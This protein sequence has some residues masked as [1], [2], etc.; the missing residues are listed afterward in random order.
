M[1]VLD[2]EKIK[3]DFPILKRKMHGKRLV[4]LDSA[5]TSQKPKQVLEAMND[6][7][8]NRNAN[9]HRGIYE[10]AEEADAAYMESKELVAKFIGAESYK[11]IVYADSTTKALNEVARAWGD[12]N[13]EK[14]D[15]ILITQ[16][17]HH[18]N[19]VPWQELAKRRGAT[20]DYAKLKDIEFVDME[21][22]KQKLELEPKIVSVA[23]V[24][25]VL[26]TINDVKEMTRLAHKAGAVVVI[27]AAQS[28]PH[29]P[30]DVK[31]IDCDFLAFSGHKM[32]GPFGIG[33]L[34]GKE[35]ALDAMPPFYFGGEM[36]RTVTFKGATWNELPWK[37]EAGT[38]NAAEAVGLG[39]AIK[40]LNAIGMAN[41]RKHEAKLTAYALEKF[42]D[43]GAK[44]YGPGKEDIEKKG[45]VI[46]FS[47]AGAHPHDIAQIFDSEGIA[48]RA[49]H[50][51]AMPLVTEIITESAV[52]RASLYIYNDE[53]DVDAAAAAIPKVREVLRIRN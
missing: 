14:G 15:H 21:D 12:A 37:F 2:V 5:A 51:C 6:F 53:A 36:I 31:E 29:M 19:L 10:I 41:V 17:E 34:Y 43:A 28:V 46:A 20:L 35:E 16:M 22:F 26:G 38:Q 23:H 13:V 39:A 42:E 44:V 11:N 1:A 40:Y 4:Y 25:N 27:D 45:G 47:I 50:H 3:K 8:E 30:V 52:A 18:S 49:G 7:Y 32:L 33:V 48:I 24:S 9:V